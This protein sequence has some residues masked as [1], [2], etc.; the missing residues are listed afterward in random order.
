MQVDINVNNTEVNNLLQNTETQGLTNKQKLVVALK[1]MTVAAVVIGLIAAS[2]CTAGM[3]S[4][5][6]VPG[7]FIAMGSVG[8]L[9]CLSVGFG[10]SAAIALVVAAKNNMFSYINENLKD[11]IKFLAVQTGI[12]LAISAVA[13]AIPSVGSYFGYNIGFNIANL[14]GHNVIQFKAG[15]MVGRFVFA[16]SDLF[17]MPSVVV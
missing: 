11:T 17:F 9:S 12:T 13:A 1:V 14:F 15:E 10:A 6:I 3:A 2:V 5:L 16:S 4:A 7:T 8:T